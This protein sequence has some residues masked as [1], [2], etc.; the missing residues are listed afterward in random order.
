MLRLGTFG[1]GLGLG[2]S[3]YLLVSLRGPSFVIVVFFLLHDEHVVFVRCLVARACAVCRVC[4]FSHPPT[5]GAALNNVIH[6]RGVCHCEELR[7]LCFRCLFPPCNL[8]IKI[9]LSSTLL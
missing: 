7:T 9:N 5:P 1:K 4:G 3:K 8:R 6:V 2:S